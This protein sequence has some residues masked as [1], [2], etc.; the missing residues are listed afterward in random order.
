MNVGFVPKIVDLL[1]GQKESKDLRVLTA[2][3]RAIGSIAMGTDTQTQT[4]LD[5]G[6]LTHFSDLLGHTD[7]KICKETMWIVSNIAAGTR[8]QVQALFEA[9]IIPLVILHLEGVSAKRS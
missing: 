6:V 1:K 3:L 9:D 7:D 2:T 4:V 8:F 5:C